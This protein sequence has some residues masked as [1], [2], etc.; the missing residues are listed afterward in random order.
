MFYSNQLEWLIKAEV[1]A[2]TV[3]ELLAVIG[4]GGLPEAAQDRLRAEAKR[5]Q[6]EREKWEN[7]LQKAFTTT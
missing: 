3:H 6:K 1:A 2:Q 4:G 7:K 5:H